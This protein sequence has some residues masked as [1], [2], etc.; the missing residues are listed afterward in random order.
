MRSGSLFWILGLAAAPGC[1]AY[2]LMS[3]AP[4]ADYDADDYGFADTGFAGEGGMDEDGAPP[5]EEDKR[6]ALLPSASPSYVFVANPPRDTVSR[7]SVPGL[8]I[9][10][11]PVGDYPLN[12]VITPDD[13]YALTL[14][15]GSDDLSVLDTEALTE[16]RVPVRPRLTSLTLSPD[17]RYALAWRDAAAEAD[18]PDDAPT[19][20]GASSASELSLVDLNAGVAT[21]VVGGAN[22]RD[23]AFTDDGARALV[24]S[25]TW[26]V[27]IDLTGAEPTASRIAIADD[28]ED[29]P[30]AEEVVLTPDGRWAFIRQFG[31]TSLLI[32]DLESG[33]L[34]EIPVGA[35]P[36]D[37]DLTADGAL[38][39]AVARAAHELW[40]F[41]T[42]D[43]FARPEVVALPTDELYGSITL[44]PTGEQGLLYSTASGLG[45]VAVWDRATGVVNDYSVIKPITGVTITADGASA[46]IFHSKDD[47]EGATVDP[48]F[49]RAW[50]LTLVDL[51][52]FFQHPLRLAAEPLGQASSED[53]L[54]GFLVLD[55]VSDLEVIDFPRLVVDE[56]P[57]PSLPL[58]VGVLPGTNLAYVNEDHELGR[59]SFYDP[60]AAAL[61]TVTGFEL[62]AGIVVY[63]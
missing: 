44:S 18:L 37:L 12:V 19:D 39:V 47:G 6:F 3:A 60:D 51:S 54:T 57:L 14:N 48:A 38:A 17:G 58:S 24:V 7:I 42:A 46:M 28:T 45:R 22:T 61:Q 15:L 11:A 49:S 35:N 43:P 62:N 20:D 34:R 16:V 25:D 56:V 4:E 27:V 31:A 9:L 36:T 13:R 63:E 5:E 52:S 23:V 50:A 33:E 10:T 29:A 21:T 1:S 2:D 8:Q 26:L 59:L 55:E 53:G 40:V 30:T 32:V 41:D